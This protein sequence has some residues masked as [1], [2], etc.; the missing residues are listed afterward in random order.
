M[1]RFSIS[2][3]AKAAKYLVQFVMSLLFSR[4]DIVIQSFASRGWALLKDSVFALICTRLFRRPLVLW[5]HGNGILG[6]GKHTK[7]SQWLIVA[8]L[9]NASCVVVLGE[10]LKGRYLTWVPPDRLRVIQ[11]GIVPSIAATTLRTDKQIKGEIVVLYF[12]NMIR[13]KGWLVTLEAAKAVLSF[14]RDV[15]FVFCGGWWP[16]SDE[17]FAL[18]LV[19][20]WGIAEN[21][22]F[23]GIVVGE[24]KTRVFESADIFVFPT[25]FPVETFGIVNLE[26]MEAGLPIITTS[27]GAIPEIVEDGVNG[28]LIAENDPEELAAKILL[29]AD[30]QDLRCQIGIRNRKKFMERFTAD[31]F[32]DRWISL[33]KDIARAPSSE[34]SCILD[35]P[36]RGRARSAG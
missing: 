30:D 16:L 17:R 33:I 36:S 21:I 25:F 15:R 6:L 35:A 5:M 20:E 31:A 13:E 23:H 24:A 9:Q 2:K 12:S 34:I 10:R 7:V 32:A 28:Y 22:E 4:I 1:G 8:A 14:R 19:S 29:L 3:V 27:R 18:Q 26:A 11:H